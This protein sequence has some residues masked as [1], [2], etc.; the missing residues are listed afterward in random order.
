MALALVQFPG[1]YLADR[2]GR[3]KLIVT[4]TF[5]FAASHVLYALAPTW[6]FIMAGAVLYSLCLIYQPALRAMTA[7]SLPPEKRGMGFSIT[8][9]IGIVSIPSPLVAG[10]LYVSHGL[11]DGMRIAYF[12]AVAFFLLAAIVRVRLR[13]TLE[14]EVDKINLMDAVGVYPRAVKEGIGVWRIIPR[15]ALYLFLIFMVGEFFASMCWPYY[16]VYATKILRIE[17]F[18]WAFLLTLNSAIMFGSALPIGKLVDMVG[19]KNPLIASNI[20]FMLGMPFFIFGDFPRVAVFFL[21]SGIGSVLMGIAYRSMEADLVPREH[22]GKVM[23][24]T[25]FFGYVLASI[26]QLVGGFLYENISPQ[27]PF[28][29]LLASTIPTAILTFLLIHEPKRREE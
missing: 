27:L 4:M 8:Q 7:D 3:R 12:M 20:L 23:G 13:E 18:Q 2:Y 28:I 21:M 19:R 9:I 24:F 29:L 1:G 11:V 26:G 6:H 16:V 22:R 17:E 10:F 25:A 5:G 14:V 15:T